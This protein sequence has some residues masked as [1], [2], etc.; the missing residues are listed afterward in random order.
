VAAAVVLAPLYK[1]LMDAV[2]YLGDHP[3]RRETM[4]R[5]RDAFR[6]TGGYTGTT[7]LVGHSLGSVIAV[8]FLRLYG[9]LFHAADRVVLVT[10]GSPLRRFLARF[11]SDRYPAP[12]DLA[13][14]LAGVLPR[15]TWFNAHRPCDP[16]GGNLGLKDSV[17]GRDISMTSVTVWGFLRGGPLAAH[18]GYFR[19]DGVRSIIRGVSSSYNYS[20]QENADG[21][22]GSS[23]GSLR[24]LENKS[25]RELRSWQRCFRLAGVLGW[26][27]GIGLAAWFAYGITSAILSRTLARD[28]DDGQQ[29]GKLANGRLMVTQ[30]ATLWILGTPVLPTYFAEIE[31]MPEGAARK[32]RRR[33]LG[34]P[35]REAFVWAAQGSVRDLDRLLFRRAERDGVV[36]VYDPRDPKRCV[37]EGLVD[38]N[39]RDDNG[40]RRMGF[41]AVVAVFTVLAY[42]GGAWSITAPERRRPRYRY[43]VQSEENPFA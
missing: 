10:M 31:F 32:V 42:A 12:C 38:K 9:P 35:D 40:A 21:T 16:I 27:G 22:C 43:R 11:F 33:P 20:S 29:N 2:L 3:L 39:W 23:I 8:D 13:D 25:R 7:I 17:H 18:L 19:D 4:E 14:H 30:S 6:A 37:L 36:V 28:I 15:F 24:R 26:L 41:F 34:V 1:V 5:M